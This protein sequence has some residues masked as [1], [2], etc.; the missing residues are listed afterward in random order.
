[1]M[2]SRVVTGRPI[3]ARQRP[4]RDKPYLGWLRTQPCAACTTR[5]GVEAAHTGNKGKG[6]SMKACDHDS[7]PLCAHCHRLDPQSYHESPLNESDW[8]ESR[9]IKLREK[10]AALR[11]EFLE[12]AA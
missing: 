5:T 8:M 9:G 10:R 4:I 3:N 2:A 12:R 6:M 11:S 7:I 1:M